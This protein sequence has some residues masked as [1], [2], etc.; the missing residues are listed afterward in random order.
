M[1]KQ[2]PIRKFST[3]P[4]DLGIQTSKYAKFHPAR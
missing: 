4:T 1:V 2:A 3:Q